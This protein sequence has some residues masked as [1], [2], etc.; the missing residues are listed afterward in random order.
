MYKVPCEAQVGE[1]FI[2]IYETGN[3]HDRY[4]RQFTEMKNRAG[5]IAGHLQ[6][7]TV[8]ELYDTVGL[9][10]GSALENL[11]TPVVDSSTETF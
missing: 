8:D 5:V 2:V 6:R 4:A 9:S 10:V 3:E 11:G 7:E 1:T